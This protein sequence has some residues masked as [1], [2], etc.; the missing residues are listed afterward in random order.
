MAMVNYDV[1]ASVLYPYV[2]VGTVLDL[3]D[4]RAIASLVGFEFLNTKYRGIPVPFHS[5]FIELNLRFYVE[6]KHR[7]GGEY[8]RGVVFIK[9]IV[10]KYLAAVTA[11][12]F[13]NEP[14]VVRPMCHHKSDNGCAYSFHNNGEWNNMI[15]HADGDWKIPRP[16]KLANFLSKRNFGFCRRRDGGTDVYMIKRDSDTYIKKG[17]PE[18]HGMEKF[19]GPEMAPFLKQQPSSAYLLNGGGIKISRRVKYCDN[20]GV[21]T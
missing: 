11:S 14:F 4:D 8:R 5:N 12:R 2:P 9:E 6:S 15:V 17:I 20:D 16:G 3:Y 18:V 21:A 7:I 19:Y 1:D 13:Y 10:P